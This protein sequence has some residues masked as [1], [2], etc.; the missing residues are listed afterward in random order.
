[1]VDLVCW[2]NKYKDGLLTGAELD[3]QHKHPIYAVVNLHLRLN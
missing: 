1:M 3:Q 2:L